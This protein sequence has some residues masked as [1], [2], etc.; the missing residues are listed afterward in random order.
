[1]L[2]LLTALT[3]PGCGTRKQA[4]YVVLANVRCPDR[5]PVKVL[6]D[7]TCPNTCGFSCLPGRWDKP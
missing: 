2:G 6:Q 4:A 3:L 1:M 5:L 7:V